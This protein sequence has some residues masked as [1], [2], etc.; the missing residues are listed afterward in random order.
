MKSVGMKIKE[1][2]ERLLL[3][4]QSLS[5]MTGLTIRSISAYETDTAKPRGSNL[6]KIA[7]ALNVS[8]AF[9]TNP[10]IDDPEYGKDTQA[11]VDAVH[12]QYGSKGARDFQGLLDGS[13]S[14]MAGGDVPQEDKE[15]F[16]EAIAAAYLQTKKDASE[17][18][19]PKKYRKD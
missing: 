13:L 10:E 8:Q 4:Q 1:S 18:F 6:R 7:E 2:R 17:R 5:E 11:Y 12:D 9:L 19:T 3:T 16:F 15:K 14:M